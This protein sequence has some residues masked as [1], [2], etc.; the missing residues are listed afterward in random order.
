MSNAHSYASL[1]GERKAQQVLNRIQQKVRE[2]S[3]KKNFLGV[4]LD[5]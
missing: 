5:S 4:M 2:A 1:D 3:N